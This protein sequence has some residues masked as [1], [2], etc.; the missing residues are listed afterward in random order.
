[1]AKRKKRK[2][3][4]S[5]VKFSSELTGLIFILIGIIGIGNFGPVGHIIKSF[6]IF[7]MGTWW[8]IAVSLLMILGLYMIVKKT[9]QNSLIAD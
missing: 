4:T 6:A 7:L 1:M 9:Y 8:A 2:T 5:K 3:T